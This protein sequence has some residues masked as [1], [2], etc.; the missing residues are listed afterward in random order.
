MKVLSLPVSRKTDPWVERNQ[1]NDWSDTASVRSF[2][3]WCRLFVACLSLINHL[4]VALKVNLTTGE[5]LMLL[6]LSGSP[7]P[8]LLNGF[9][10]I[11]F[12]GSVL[13]QSNFW[14]YSYNHLLDLFLFSTLMHSLWRSSTD[15]RCTH[16]W[17]AAQTNYSSFWLAWYGMVC[18]GHC[19][20]RCHRHCYLTTMNKLCYRGH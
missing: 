16:N 3:T 7:G 9:W 2:A 10:K 18:H 11:K 1:P 13:C 12:V 5:R 6:L 8:I 15:Q 20:D 14:S 17:Q 19:H 4:T